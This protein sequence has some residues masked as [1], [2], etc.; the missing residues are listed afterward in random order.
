MT[1]L[2]AAVDLCAY[3]IVQEALAN[4]A[5]HAASAPV[6]VTVLR[7][8]RELDLL[9]RNGPAARPTVAAGRPAAPAIAG[10]GVRG[11]R[12]RVMMLSGT[13]YAGLTAD[14][15]FEVSATL[16]LTGDRS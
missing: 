16:P 12:E 3:R 13:L 6:Q 5:Q 1:G 11:M 9:V 4:A 7:S 14:G 10:H 8:E 15:G 2:P